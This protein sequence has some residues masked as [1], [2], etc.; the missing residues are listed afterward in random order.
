MR[1]LEIRTK[2]YDPCPTSTA[3]L[4]PLTDEASTPFIVAHEFFDALPIHVFQSVPSSGPNIMKSTNTVLPTQKPSNEWRELLVAPVSPYASH[5]RIQTPSHELTPDFTLTISTE[6]TPHSKLLPTTSRRYTALLPHTGSTIEIS[7][8]SL[9][10]AANIAIRIG[11]P[12]GAGKSP[13]IQ[14]SSGHAPSGAALIVDYGPLSTIPTN[15]LRGIKAHRRTSPFALA[16]QVDISADVD[17]TALAHAAIEASPGVAVHGPV[18]QAAW[19]GAMGGRERVEML[20]RAAGDEEG[21][22]RIEGAWRRLVDRSPV[23][24]GRVYKVMAVVPFREGAARKPVGFGGDV[25]G[26]L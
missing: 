25:V 8:E 20:T 7:P 17:F 1:G 12:N 21:R 9:T 5:A 19:L 2:R 10:L 15:S 3:Y 6:P 16:G 26:G 23:G 24:M 22:K 14:R 4:T 11:G 13:T 18:E